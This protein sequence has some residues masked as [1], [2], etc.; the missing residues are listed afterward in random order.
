MYISAQFEAVKKTLYSPYYLPEDYILLKFLASISYQIFR[1]NK[2]FS[3]CL[4][5]ANCISRVTERPSK[6]SH[7]GSGPILK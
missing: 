3:H 2:E 7:F 4:K 5:I 1:E 6:D